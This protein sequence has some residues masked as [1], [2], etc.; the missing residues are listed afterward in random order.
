MKVEVVSKDVGVGKNGAKV[1]V[2]QEYSPTCPRVKLWNI[3]L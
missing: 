3:S 1:Q 2:A